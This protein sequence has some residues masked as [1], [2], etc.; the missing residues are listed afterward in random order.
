[1]ERRSH[2]RKPKSLP[3]E[4]SWQEAAARLKQ[5][6]KIVNASPGGLGLLVK[7]PVPVGSLVSI[8]LG[9]QILLGMVEHQ[10]TSIGGYIIGVEIDSSVMPLATQSTFDSI[11]KARL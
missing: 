10:S 11:A 7:L 2:V 8:S 3:V 6:G 5:L 4:I 9:N 1:M